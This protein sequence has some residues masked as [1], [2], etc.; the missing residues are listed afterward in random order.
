MLKVI[1]DIAVSP[2][3]SIT[4]KI[5]T[6]KYQLFNGLFTCF[7]IRNKKEGN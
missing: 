2:L 7:K 1:A 5:A 3:L 4:W 6:L